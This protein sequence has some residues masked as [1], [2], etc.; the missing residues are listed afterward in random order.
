MLTRRAPKPNARREF[1]LKQRE[2]IEASPIIATKFPQL[3][4][5]GVVLEFYNPAG[6]TRNG[7][8]KCTMNVDHARSALWFACPAAECT[9]GDFDLSGALVKAVAG[10]QKAVSGTASCHGTR[11]RGN[12]EKVPCLTLLRYRLKLKYD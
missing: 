3:K 10:R 2:R 9:A 1:R 12:D 7:G 11:T 8:L 6:T 5:L 4:A